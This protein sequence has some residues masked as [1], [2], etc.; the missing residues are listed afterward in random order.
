MQRRS[1]NTFLAVT[2]DL[3]DFDSPYG[4]IHPRHKIPVG[5]RLALGARSVAYKER[6]V[7]SAGEAFCPLLHASVMLDPQA[8]QR[9]AESLA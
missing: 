5:D 2:T 8:Y 1:N 4:S 7:Y 9:A 6:G 3:A